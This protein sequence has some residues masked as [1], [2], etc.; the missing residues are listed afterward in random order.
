MAR[1]PSRID[2]P[3][4]EFIEHDKKFSKVF[5]AIQELMAPP[6]NS[7]RRPIGFSIKKEE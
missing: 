3:D 2:E 4:R 1:V 6:A 7:K 5:A